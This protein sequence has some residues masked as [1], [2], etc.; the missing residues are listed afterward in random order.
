LNNKL[1]QI[2]TIAFQP[3][4]VPIYGLILLMAVPQVFGIDDLWGKALIILISIFIMVLLPVLW[5]LLL[6]KLKYITTPQASNKKERIPAYIFTLVCYVGEFFFLY[7]IG[8]Y[9]IASLILMAFFALLT[10]FVVNFFWKIS[11]HATGISGL[12]GSI[13][14]ISFFYGIFNPAIIVVTILICGLVCSARIQ[15][16]AHTPM[17]LLFGVFL[18]FF[19][20]FPLPILIF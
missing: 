5:Y 6:V 19:Y 15:L 16:N 17:Q 14:Y 7:A 18:G 20:L 11:A 13:L 9:V 4:I 2:L 12:L 1:A 10:L 8:A 3:L